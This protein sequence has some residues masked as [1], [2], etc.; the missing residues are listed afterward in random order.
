MSDYHS[1]EAQGLEFARN[2]KAAIA[3][4]LEQAEANRAYG[5]ATGKSISEADTVML[6]AE[7]LTSE[8]HSGQIGALR[9]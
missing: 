2:W 5:T 8:I 4:G 1:T 7:R 6:R 3:K 9:S